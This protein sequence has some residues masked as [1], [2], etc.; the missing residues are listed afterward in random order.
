MMGKAAIRNDGTRD[1]GSNPTPLLLIRSLDK[2]STIDEIAEALR[3]AEGPNG[4]G[5]QA[6]KRIMLIRD[7][8]TSQSWGFAFVEM[9]DV[10]VSYP[11]NYFPTVVLTLSFRLQNP[12]WREL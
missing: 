1:I 12:C 10:D 11:L 3:T 6:M 9:L 2:G 5:A 8:G 4:G 7:R